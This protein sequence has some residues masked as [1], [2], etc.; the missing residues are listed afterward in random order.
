MTLQYVCQNETRRLLVRGHPTLN[1]IDYLEVLD[2]DAPADSPRQQTL[3]VH[4]FKPLTPLT[5]SNVVIE[6]GVRITPV[7][8]RWAIRAADASPAMVAAGQITEDER[9]FFTGLQDADRVLAVRTGVAGDFSAYRL[10]LVQSPTDREPPAG[11][12]PLL[13][14]VEFSFKVE[15]PSDFDCAPVTDCPPETGPEPLI[16]YLAKDYASFRRLMLDRLAVIMPGWTERS[17]ADVGIAL[18]ET[19]AYVGDHLSYYQDAVAT[20][21]YLGT[22]RRRVSVRRHARLLDYAM[23]DGCNARAWVCFDVAP[24][25][26][27]DGL[28]LPAGTQLLTQTGAARGVLPPARLDAALSQGAQVFETMHDLTLRSDHNEIHFY[29]WADQDCCLPTGATAASLEN[30]ANQLQELRAGDV[31]VFEEVLGPRTGLAVDADPSRRHAVRITRTTPRVDPLNG[32]DVLDIAWDAEDALPFP[33][34]LSTTITNDSGSVQA[35]SNITVA[36]GNVALADEGRTVSGE[37]LIPALVPA[38]GRYR[39][40]LQRTGLT[41]RVPFAAGTARTQPAARALAQDPRAALPAVALEADGEDWLPRRDLLNSDR[42]APEFVVETENDGRAYLRFGDGVLGLQPAGGAQFAVSYRV[43]NGRAGNV[44]AGAIAHVVLPVTGINDVR[45]PLPA[46]GGEDPESM[47][48]VRLLAPQAFRTQERAVT[49]TDYA[50]VTQR[51]PE[52]Q[53]AAATLRWTGSWHTMF[54]TVD[55]TGGRP[56]DAAF[57]QELRAFLERFRLA[58]YDL[59]ID[60]PRF[61]PLD[62]ALHVCVAPGYVRS[63]VKAALLDA[64]SARNL[65]GGRQGF[66]HPDR[67]TFGQ[68]VYLSQIVATAMEVPGVEWVDVGRFQRWGQRPQGELAAGRLSL[69]RLEIARL[70][71][72]PN[73]R[74][75][76]RLELTLEGGL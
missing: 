57:E 60:G 51:H 23:H 54:I 13:S 44:G 42:F 31:L 7:A 68:P 17:P 16:D 69:G 34:W 3:L 39:P 27:A 40:R 43:G 37:T 11:F 76:G 70:D 19:L 12:D 8:V 29:T 1:G 26:G 32:T 25:G 74:E 73:A 67:Y 36:R 71:N 63:T 6:G 46:R 28:L 75:N 30:P 4:C 22:A 5:G 56:V 41:F 47:E 45:N 59:E 33:L 55:R 18:V 20:E 61:V 50:A 2:S 21:G 48:E 35:V 62:L 38:A 14:D 15:C 10:R 66:F 58:G 52:V 65:P 53:K 9:A 72:D 49:E 24:A 64:F